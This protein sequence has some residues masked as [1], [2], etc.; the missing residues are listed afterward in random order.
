MTEKDLETPAKSLKRA[1]KMDAESLG[2]AKE[3][4]FLTPRD[5]LRLEK[6][7]DY[8]PGTLLHYRGPRVARERKN[9][10]S[11]YARARRKSLEQAKGA[12][13][14]LAFLARVMGDDW[15]LE[16]VTHRLSRPSVESLTAPISPLRPG[17]LPVFLELVAR[18]TGLQ[19]WP[20][21]THRKQQAA[22]GPLVVVHLLAALE[23][24]LN[25]QEDG[26]L[27]HSLTYQVR[28]PPPAAVLP[29]EPIAAGGKRRRSGG[30]K[31]APRKS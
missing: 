26:Y 24:G 31:V 25:A 21:P 1:P 6:G 16:L 13:E 30:P 10:A 28:P 14:D 22:K 27:Q 12:L 2:R 15:L 20:V 29:I 7:P 11:A 4:H 5:R 17:A 18:Q 19:R 23:R 3:G 8:A 9:Q